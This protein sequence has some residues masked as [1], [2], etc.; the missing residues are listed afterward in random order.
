MESLLMLLIAASAFSLFWL[1]IAR[2]AHP[3]DEWKKEKTG[4]FD[5]AKGIF[6]IFIGAVLVI[7][8]FEL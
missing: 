2:L 5:M 3:K 8:L 7:A 4:Y 1:A 6:V